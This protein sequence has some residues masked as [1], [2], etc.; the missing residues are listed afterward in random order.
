[1]LNLIANT[2][3]EKAVY[4]LLNPIISEKGLK[5]VKI[6]F[7]NSK[8][9][10]L[11]IFLDKNDGKLTIDECGIISMEINSLLDIENIIKDPFRLEVSSAGIDRHLTSLED[12]NRYE[13]CN[14]KVKSETYTERGKLI[15]HGPTSLTLSNKNGEKSIDLSSVLDVKIDL[16]GMSLETI[17]EMEFK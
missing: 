5:I 3:L 1:M 16:D 14:I 10:K 4:E 9:S 6:Q 13:N 7:Q 8:K 11:L 2:D 12:F 15:R 17:K